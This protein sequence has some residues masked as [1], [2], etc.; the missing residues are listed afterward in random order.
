MSIRRSRRR[1]RFIAFACLILF[2]VL[3]AGCSS[4][5]TSA[6]GGTAGAAA[7]ALRA[8]PTTV[9]SLTFDDGLAS[10]YT[11]MSLLRARGMVGTFYIISGLVGSSPYYMPWPEVHAI[12]DAGGEIGGHTVHHR[13][14][15][16]LDPATARSEACGA[17][18]DLLD[19]GFSPVA[20]FA[21][22]DA[23]VNST[24]EHVVQQCG[25]TSGR[26]VGNL[27]GPE[28][29]CPYAGPVPPTDPFNLS[30]IDGSTTSTSL[31]DLQA[32]VTGA[33]THGGGWVPLVFHGICDD[34]C[35]GVNSVSTATF[36]SFLD[37]LAPRSATGTV[38]RTVGQVISGQ[39][40]LRAP[41]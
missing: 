9:V 17:R 32:A 3:C 12:A 11:A 5:P 20:S 8:A 37:W 16:E 34:Q 7:P 39:T 19:Q 10:H 1:A 31:A 21:Y 29:P 41:Q 25:Y 27:F 30:T 2:P 38:V 23:D 15:T 35:T 13:D 40:H 24:A 33:E 18:T 22:P 36:T 6:P 14:L 4:P 26:G 28:C